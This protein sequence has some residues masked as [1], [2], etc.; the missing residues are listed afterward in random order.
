[1]KLIYV[2]TSHRETK[3]IFLF[4]TSLNKKF[5]K[6]GVVTTNPILSTS[7]FHK[8]ADGWKILHM[9]ETWLNMTV[10]SSFVKSSHKKP[11]HAGW[12]S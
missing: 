4:L 9:H 1:M 6:I 7:T 10:D 2:Q 12:K 11:P 8:E 5:E 3:K